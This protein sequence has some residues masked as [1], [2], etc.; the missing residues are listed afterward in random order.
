M[1]YI[2]DTVL[3]NLLGRDSSTVAVVVFGHSGP[4]HPRTPFLCRVF[5]LPASC[6][7][8]HSACSEPSQPYQIINQEENTSVLF[9]A[10]FACLEVEKELK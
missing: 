9:V 8:Q 7:L 4:A 6:W 2:V 5:T 3:K 1:F 10:R